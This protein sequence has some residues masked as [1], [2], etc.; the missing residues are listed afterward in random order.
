[1]C[2]LY[3]YRTAELANFK[4]DAWI[5]RNE[6]YT[7]S[8]KIRLKW[9]RGLGEVAWPIFEYW[10]SFYI[11][12]TDTVIDFKFGATAGGSHKFKGCAIECAHPDYPLVAA[13]TVSYRSTC[14]SVLL[15]EQ[16]L[17]T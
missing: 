10:D 11:S 17:L 1:L 16:Q 13:K 4:F 9:I 15:I 7:K 2:P 8:A 5:D 14:Y 6:Y 12:G 3:I